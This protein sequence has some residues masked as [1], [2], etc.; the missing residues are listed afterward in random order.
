MKPINQL[1]QATEAN[2]GDQI[3]I[4][5]LT[6]FC[7][8]KITLAQ[9]WQLFTKEGGMVDPLVK[10]YYSTSSEGFVVPVFP[11]NN[12]WVIVSLNTGKLAGTITLPDPDTVS[13]MAEVQYTFTDSVDDLDFVGGTMFNGGPIQVMRGDTLSL[14]LEKPG[15]RW[16]VI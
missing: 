10:Q 4:F 9:I 7:T 6:Q 15:N 11:G 2:L 1:N 12:N 13:D 3:P 8:A 5:S 14:R 16:F